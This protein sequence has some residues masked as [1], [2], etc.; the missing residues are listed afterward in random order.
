M[1]LNL[2]CHPEPDPQGGIY[3]PMPEEYIDNIIKAGTENHTAEVHLWVDSKRLTNLQMDYVRA[4]LKERRDNVHLKDLRD[5][6][7]YATEEFFDREETNPGWRD[8][9]NSTIWLQVDAAKILV[10]LQGNFDQHFFADLDHAHVKVDSP[11]IQTMLENHGIMIGSLHKYSCGFENRLWGF[12]NRH[13]DGFV[14]RR[15]FFE[16][17]YEQALDEAKWDDRLGFYSLI[18]KLETLLKTEQ[19]KKEDICLLISGE[20]LEK[21]EQ[22]GHKFS[23][24]PDQ[25]KPEIVSHAELRAHGV[26]NRAAAKRKL[27]RLRASIET[28]K[29]TSLARTM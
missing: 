26:F 14:N 24:D 17:Y 1:W 8:T 29:K 5:I 23:G 21:A 13:G 6:P 3:R 4:R 15:G 9:Y 12:E 27:R 11:K 28:G 2:D 18:G 25:E 19:I 20:G 22:P 10:S 16:E 7:A